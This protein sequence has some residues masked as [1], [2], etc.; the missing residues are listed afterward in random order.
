MNKEF[1]PAEVKAIPGSE[2]ELVSMVYEEYD[3]ELERTFMEGV[4]FNQELYNSA[5]FPENTNRCGCCGSTNLKYA[6]QVVHKPTKIGFHVG[7]DCAENIDSLASNLTLSA[8]MLKERSDSRKRFD[9]W[10][11]QNPEHAEIVAW[12]D[13][14][15][16]YIAGDIAHKVA[17]Y[18]SISEKQVALLYRLRDQIEQ[19][20]ARKAAELAKLADAPDLAEG[21]MEVEGEILSIKSQE[22]IYGATWKMLVALANGNKLWGS[23]P[24]AIGNAERGARIAFTAMITPS[25]DDKHFGFFKRPTKARFLD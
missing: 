1:T 16:H 25:D 13:K 17:K 9:K 3:H 2:L 24:S 14:S 22:S 7:R 10:V 4:V 23:L 15:N 18:G 20:E 19:S 6:C 12:A 5:S 8:K 21:R 11:H